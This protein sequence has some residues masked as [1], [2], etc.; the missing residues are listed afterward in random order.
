M[1]KPTI[2]LLL[3]PCL[4]I[5]GAFLQHYMPSWIPDIAWIFSAAISIVCVLLSLLPWEDL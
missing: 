1:K 3:F 2:K 5:S 4:P